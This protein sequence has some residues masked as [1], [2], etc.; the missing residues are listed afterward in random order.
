MDCSVA[1]DTPLVKVSCK[2]QSKNIINFLCRSKNTLSL[3]EHISW[4]VL[5]I[6]L[7]QWQIKTCNSGPENKTPRCSLHQSNSSLVLQKL[8]SWLNQRWWFLG[9]GQM[10]RTSVMR[11]LVYLAPWLTINTQHRW[12][13]CFTLSDRKGGFYFEGRSS[14]NKMKMAVLFIFLTLFF[15]CKLF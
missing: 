6:I 9:Q 12:T 11:W 2:T 7:W 4:I 5:H 13:V 10:L 14:V 1:R 8:R 15:Y 3:T